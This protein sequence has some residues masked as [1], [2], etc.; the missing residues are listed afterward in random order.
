MVRCRPIGYEGLRSSGSSLR[1]HRG[2]DHCSAHKMQR[3]VFHMR[4]SSLVNTNLIF[5]KVKLF[6]M[7]TLFFPDLSWIFRTLFSSVGQSLCGPASDTAFWFTGNLTEHEYTGR[8]L[9]YHTEPGPLVL[10]Y[11]QTQ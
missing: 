4:K 5:E 2:L 3:T 11:L 9:A 6:Y 10:C 1:N 8:M 7:R